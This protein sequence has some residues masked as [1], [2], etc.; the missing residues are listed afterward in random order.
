MKMSLLL[1]QAWVSYLTVSCGGDYTMTG[2]GAFHLGSL[3]MDKV[4][5]MRRGRKR[6]T[7]SERYPRRTGHGTTLRRRWLIYFYTIDYQLPLIL[8]LTHTTFCT[9]QICDSY[10]CIYYDSFRFPPLSSSCWL[11]L[12]ILFVFYSISPYA[13]YIIDRDHLLPV[14]H[15]HVIIFI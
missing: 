12:F 11:L 9:W 7:S 15:P 14:Y 3:L 4:D 8:S 13:L 1:L 10:P 2:G 6:S 5:N